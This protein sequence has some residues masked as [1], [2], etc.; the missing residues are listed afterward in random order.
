MSFSSAPSATPRRFQ[1]RLRTL[2]VATM[3]AACLL[4]ASV[5]TYKWRRRVSREHAVQVAISQYGGTYGYASAFHRQPNDPSSGILARHV[6]NYVAKI[7]LSKNAWPRAEQT[8]AG[9]LLPDCGDAEAPILLGVPKLE[10]LDLSD[11]QV[12]D[13]SVATLKHLRALRTLNLRNTKVTP[14][15]VDELRRALPACR[16]EF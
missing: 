12:S 7:D 6:F 14:Q 3:I 16:I 13:R 11:T 8:K 4:G 5:G 2:V 10:W 15:G 1:F 9:V